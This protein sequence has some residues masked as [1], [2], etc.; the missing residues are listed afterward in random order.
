M[1]PSIYVMAKAGNEQ[2]TWFHQGMIEIPANAL[3]ASKTTF[4]VAPF[5]SNA[6]ETLR[7]QTAFEVSKVA[8]TTSPCIIRSRKLDA[9]VQAHV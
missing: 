8:Y 9:M 2:S 3:L 4:P 5:L 6:V 1:T 7:T